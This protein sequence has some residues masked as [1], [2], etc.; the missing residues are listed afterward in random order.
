MCSCL[1]NEHIFVMHWSCLWDA[2]VFEKWAHL[3]DALVLSLQCARFLKNEHD[4]ANVMHLLIFAMRSC[5]P[6]FMMW[7]IVESIIELYRLTYW[8]DRYSVVVAPC[9]FL[10]FSLNISLFF[11]CH[12][13]ISNALKIPLPCVRNVSNLIHHFPVLHH[14][15]VVDL[16]HYIQGDQT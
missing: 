9:L 5:L 10:D 12:P 13:S 16:T 15:N 1:K 4:F 11:Q 3:C 8:L 7:C 14:T 2:L 6:I